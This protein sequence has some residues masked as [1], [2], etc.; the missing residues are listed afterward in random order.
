MT[1]QKQTD[2]LI[3]DLDRAIDEA[4]ASI[5]C[6]DYKIKITKEPTSD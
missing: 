6:G 3:S 4:G 1:T 5:E 2:T